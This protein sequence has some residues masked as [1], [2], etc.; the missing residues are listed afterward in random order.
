VAFLE[1]FVII[2]FRVLQLAVLARAL[3]SW[4]GPDVLTRFPI[5][6]PLWDITE[7][8][9]APIRRYTSMGM[10]DM[11][12]LIALIILQVVEAILLQLFARAG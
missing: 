10:L 5:A 1:T 11:S 4:F 12:P 2:L 3:L 6:K 7:P 8:I 9:L